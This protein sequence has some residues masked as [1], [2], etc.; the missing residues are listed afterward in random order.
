MLK[1]LVSGALVLLIVFFAVTQPSK[2]LGVASSVFGDLH[3]AANS[4]KHFTK[5]H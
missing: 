2:T 4:V 1:K 3:S 5:H